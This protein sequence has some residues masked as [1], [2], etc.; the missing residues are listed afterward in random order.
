MK[1]LLVRLIAKSLSEK[2]ELD[3][4]LPSTEP[5]ILLHLICV[6]EV[7]GGSTKISNE[8]ATNLNTTSPLWV[9]S[10]AN[11]TDWEHYARVIYFN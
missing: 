9:Y 7:D 6:A 8:G 10:S 5:M 3:K 11:D 4:I 1:S 2:S